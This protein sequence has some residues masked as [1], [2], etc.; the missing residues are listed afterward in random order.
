MFATIPNQQFSKTIY[1]TQQLARC[2]ELR[3]KQ[4]FNF[5][6][7]IF[8]SSLTFQVYNQVP[9]HVC[10]DPHLI[11][12]YASPL[13]VKSQYFQVVIS[14]FQSKSILVHLLGKNVDGG[15]KLEF[16]RLPEELQQLIELLTLK[17]YSW[18]LM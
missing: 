14:D 7:R 12:S 2:A 15:C 3:S 13:Q 4:D 11:D 8:L 1:Y 9:H 6:T 5:Y 16:D 18:L 17:N 10:C